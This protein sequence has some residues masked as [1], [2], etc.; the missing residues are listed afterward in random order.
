MING[1]HNVQA[2]DGGGGGGG[3]WKS[4]TFLETQS[5]TME[6]KTDNMET[7]KSIRP[8]EQHWLHGVSSSVL[9]SPNRPS[10]EL[11]ADPQVCVCAVC[12]FPSL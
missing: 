11:Q 3:G 9:L 1:V 5:A 4:Y 12:Q 2:R 10:G 7:S 6:E 8:C